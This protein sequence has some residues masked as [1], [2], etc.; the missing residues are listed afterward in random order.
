MNQEHHILRASQIPI[1]NASNMT[2]DEVIEAFVARH[3]ELALILSDLHKESPQSRPQHHMIV[4]Q[5]GMGKTTL[6]LRLAAEIRSSHLGDTFIPLV[7]AEEQYEVDRLSKFWLNCL[8][9]LAD[10]AERSQDL[11][12]VN[13]ID[14]TVQGLEQFLAKKPKEEDR[15]ARQCLRELLAA[16]QK[17]NRRLVL[18]VDNIQIVFDRIGEQAH[19]LREV[20]QRAGGPI[21]IAAAPSPPSQTHDYG[22]AFYDH[23]KT[24][25][26]NAL[27]ADE[28][29]ELIR[30]FA[31]KSDRK[32]VAAR[33]QRHK[34]RIAALHQ[35]TG[36]SPRTAA[37][38]FHLYAEDFSPSVFQDLE[39]LLDLVTPLY[40]ARL[41]E[42]SDQAQVVV[43]AVGQHWSPIQSGRLAELTGLP[44]STISSQLDRLQKIGVLE[45]VPMHETSVKGYQLGERF[46]NIWLLMRSSSRRQR[47]KVEF[48]TRFLEAFY[49]PVERFQLA[50]LL[51]TER[52]RS[53]DRAIFSMAVAST[54]KETHRKKELERSVHLD[55]L[56]QEATTK[57]H[58]LEKILDLPN[59][60]Q[61]TL[62][63]D[64]LRKKLQSL[65]CKLKS[66][67]KAEFAEKVLGSRDLFR[68]GER[69]RLASKDSL[70][71]EEVR[72]LL[73]TIESARQADIS[74]FGQEAVEWLENRIK[75][76]Q[77]RTVGDLEDWER[78]IKE[79]DP[80]CYGIIIRTIPMD[81][82]SDLDKKSRQLLLKRY[83]PDKSAQAP[84]W[85]VWGNV[86]YKLQD[87]SRA[88]QAYRK[89]VES[90]PKDAAAWNNLGLL[91][92][93]D[94]SQVD[95][96]EE[97]Y[98]KAIEID[99]T[100]E[101]AI[102]NLIGLELDYLGAFDKA[103]RRIDQLKK[104]ESELKFQERVPIHSMLLA[105]YES[106]WGIAAAELRRIFHLFEDGL[107]FRT[108]KEWARLAAVLIHLGY[109]DELLDLVREIGKTD[110]VRPWYEAIQ[111]H[112][113]G[114]VG[115]LK[116]IPAEVRPTAEW[117]F[118][119]IENTLNKLPI[120]TSRRKQP[121]A[122]RKK[123]R[124]SKAT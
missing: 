62:D 55:A 41:E 59:L 121:A 82:V 17:M 34:G 21:L 71:A 72:R 69:E 105:A 87:F 23:F 7:F 102:S 120:E 114:E 36:G 97:A 3:K 108:H 66:I 57:R 109:Q 39:R 68:R 89:A 51:V 86:L 47:R 107:S 28:I 52:N 64:R 10:E 58:E 65:V 94:P 38:L 48:L 124:R 103:R 1:Y 99:P 110:Q 98:R 42:L 20:L 24:H 15:L 61:A 31:L 45:A 12:A 6:L 92:S 74:E 43:S 91:L 84:Q 5:R 67:D 8:D 2:D 25:Y 96:A 77:I 93:D 63:F 95:A 54:L 16:A 75:S 117:F 104:L 79:S 106:N 53:P 27:S 14:A 56:A 60:P 22:A 78:T 85:L 83:T 90:D 116:G 35:L 32:K 50:G 18:L 81:L 26:L 70:N 123:K 4:G 119:S 76:G 73:S 88:E 118:K 11:E 115:Y 113:I 44:S 13:T 33:V 101:L 29:R 46:F 49:Q 111:A 37:I 100:S 122:K 9:S 19:A 40:K 112:R 80:I 30:N